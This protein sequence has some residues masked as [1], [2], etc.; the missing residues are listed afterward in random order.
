MTS[1][2]GKNNRMLLSSIMV[3]GAVM[4][5]ALGIRHVQGLFLLPMTF[6]RGWGREVF[7]FAMAVQNLVWGL[8]QPFAGMI[9]DRFGSKHV[10]AVGTLLYAG[11]LTLMTHASSEWELVLSAGVLIGLALSCTAFG[12]IYGCISR[13]APEGLRS[14]SVGLAG[15]IGGAGL[16]VLVPV[17]QGLQSSVGWSAALLTMAVAIGLLSP[18]AF[19]LS[20]A[21]HQ[22]SRAGRFKLSMRSA[23]SEAFSHRGF[24][25]LNLGFLAC[26]FQLAFIAGHLPAYLL[27]R[28]LDARHAV[29]G[30]AIVGLTNVAGTYLCGWLG[31][32]Y[33]PKYLLG[34]LYLARTVFMALFLLLPLTP[35]SVY[36]F[37]GAMGLLWLGTVPLT[38]GILAGVFGVQYISTLFGFVFFGHQLGGFLGVWLGGHVFDKYASYNYVWACSMLLGVIA[39]ALHLLIDDK[40]V[41]GRVQLQAT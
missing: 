26:G 18:G 31:G 27:D 24:W 12:V 15:A 41:H 32:R 5:L 38:N 39:S 33:R 40:P 13:I 35:E 36:L 22:A 25:L 3:G 9:A 21:R 6:D 8:A 10:V 1:L 7:S 23:L 16:F 37:C 34:G 14:V 30:L 20:D 17:T 4:A 2:L 11:G 28:G 29:A 19:V